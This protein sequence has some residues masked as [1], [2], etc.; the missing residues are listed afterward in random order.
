MVVGHYWN[1]VI[2]P[3]DWAEEKKPKDVELK[4]CVDSPGNLICE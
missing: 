1:D 3:L 4:S 2:L